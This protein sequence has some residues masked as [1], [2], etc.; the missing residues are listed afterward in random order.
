M[1]FVTINLGR[2]SGARQRTTRR[3]EMVGVSGANQKKVSF[4]GRKPKF[5]LHIYPFARSKLAPAGEK[6]WKPLRRFE[7]QCDTGKD[8]FIFEFAV[9][10]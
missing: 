8:F 9:T 10:H 3:G 5:V 1:I 7:T 4:S 6:A 2:A